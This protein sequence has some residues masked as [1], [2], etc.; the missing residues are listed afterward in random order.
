MLFFHRGHAGETKEFNVMTSRDGTLTDE[1][2]G[3]HDYLMAKPGQPN[4]MSWPTS[5]EF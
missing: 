2:G 4:A 3:T 1:M 5:L